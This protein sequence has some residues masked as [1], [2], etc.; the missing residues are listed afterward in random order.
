VDVGVWMWLWICGCV[1]VWVWVYGCVGM[2]EDTHFYMPM[3]RV[4]A[5]V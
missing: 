5:L 4:N 2:G 1:D 3:C